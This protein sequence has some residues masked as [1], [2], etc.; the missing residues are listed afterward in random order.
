MPTAKSARMSEPR[1][2]LKKVSELARIT[3]PSLR[4]RAVS[5]LV[6][7]AAVLAATW[8]AVSP[9]RVAERGSSGGGES[10]CWVG[11]ATGVAWTIGRQG[12]RGPGVGAPRA[13]ALYY[14]KDATG[15]A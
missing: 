3:S 9:C 7:P 15:H 12:G 11:F 4:W 6:R 14:I 8:A 13:S 10:C 1:T 2:T 5:A